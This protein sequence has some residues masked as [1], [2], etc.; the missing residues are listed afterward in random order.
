MLFGALSRGSLRGFHPGGPLRGLGPD[1]TRD[2]P[3]K[4]DRDPPWDQAGGR[5]QQRPV[6]VSRISRAAAMG[7]LALELGLG[8]LAGAAQKRLQ[9]QEQRTGSPPLL[10]EATAERLVAT[11]SRARGAALK[12]GQLLSMADS[13]VLT[14]QLQQILAQLRQS[15]EPMPGW[16]SR[17]VLEQELGPGWQQQLQEFQ[18]VPV[19]AASL[20]QVHRARL[21]DGREVALKVQYPGVARSIGSD[22]ENLLTLLSLSPGLPKGLFAV[23]SLR[24]LQRELELECDYGR[25]AASAR[26]FRSL[27]GGDPFFRVPRVLPQLSSRRVLCTEWGRGAALERCRRLGQERRDQICSELLRLCLLELFQFRFMQ[28]DPNWANFLYEPESNTVT[29]LDFGACREF[30]REFTDLYIEV[31][32]AAAERD[33]EKILRRSEELKFL[34]GFESPAL[35]SLHVQAVLLLGEPFWGPQPFD[36]GAQG[37]AQGVGRLL[38]QML[39]GRLGPPPE[40]SYALHRKLGGLF[41]AC[42]RL[43]GR[44]RCRELFQQVYEGYWDPKNR[45]ETPKTTG[46]T[47]EMEPDSGVEPPPQ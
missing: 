12:L 47:P 10:S 23:P 8:A 22:I 36:F 28:T 34:T 11:L 3:Q 1:P 45:E 43:G 35:R 27:L 33:K 20:G 6:P 39:R 37:T 7:G 42:A 2:P 9:G 25:E 44:V 31:I 13:S 24:A 38:P 5:R 41:L 32:R 18:E 40:P 30:E 17:A 21:R 46:S 16:Q 26:R 29:L 15:A 14:P 19:A 4:T